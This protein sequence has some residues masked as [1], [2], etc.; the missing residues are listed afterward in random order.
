MRY[1]P[2]HKK[3]THRRIVEAASREFRR[4]GF[5]GVGIASLLGS[6]GLTHGGFYAHFADKEAL[7]VESFEL[8][9]D[10]SIQKMLDGLKHGGFPAVLDY[11]LSEEHRD[12]IASGCPLPAL[13]SELARRS[14]SSR[15]ALTRRLSEALDA[16]GAFLPGENPAKKSE[17]ALFMLSSMAGAVSLARTVTDSALSAAILRSTR[18]YLSHFIEE[19]EETEN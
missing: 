16:L 1:K 13:A 3:E 15:E 19:I 17:K 14:P 6:L 7:I 8:A 11:Y 18:E 9:L 2:E 5:D 4:Q 12:N 10:Q